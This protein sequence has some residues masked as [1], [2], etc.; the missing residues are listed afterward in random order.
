MEELTSQDFEKALK[1]KAVIDFWAPWCGPC[2]MMA[3]HFGEASKENPDVAFFKVNVDEDPGLAA[4]Y[5][6]RSIPTLVFLKDG[7]E[8]ER[9]VGAVNKDALNQAV[10]EV[11][12]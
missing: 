7:E 4:R 3:P 8:V 5:G 2:Q 10:R 6:V 1:G 9:V 11:F 12:Y